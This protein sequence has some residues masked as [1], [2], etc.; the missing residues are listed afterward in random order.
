MGGNSSAGPAVPID[1]WSSIAHNLEASAADL[2]DAIDDTEAT[3]RVAA[4][5]AIVATQ[6]PPRTLRWIGWV[7]STVTDRMPPWGIV[8]VAVA[9]ISAATILKILRVW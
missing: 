7:W 6:A 9:T 8:V 3:T 2:P 4:L 1:E 5:A